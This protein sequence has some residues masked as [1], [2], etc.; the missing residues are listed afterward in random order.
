MDIPK[1]IIE[2]SCVLIHW[3]DLNFTYLGCNIEYTKYIGLRSQLDIIGKTDF[4]LFSSNSADQLRRNDKEA[5]KKGASCFFEEEITLPNG[6]TLS[7][8]TQKIP[9]FNDDGAVIGLASVLYDK[10]A[11]TSEN[12]IYIEKEKTEIVLTSLINKLPAHIYWKNDRLIFQGCN[13]AQAKSAGFSTPQQMIGK[14][15]YEMPWKKEATALRA[16][17]LEVM[18]TKKCIVQE[19]TSQLANTNELSTFLSEKVPLIDKKGNVIGVLGLSFNITERVKMEEEL[20]QTKIA[21]EAANRAKTEFIANM[22]HDL[23]TPIIGILGIANLLKDKM[24]ADEEKQYVQWVNESGEQLLNLLNDI[25]TK[26]SDGGEDQK[27][28]EELFDLRQCIN[29]IVQLEKPAIEL[30]QLSLNVMIAQD[31]PCYIISDRSKIYRILLNLLGNA[32]KFT[33]E[34][35]ITIEIKKNRSRLIFKIIDTGIGIAKE[36]QEKIFE[37]FFQ[38]AR[39]SKKTSPGYGIGLNLV[40][41]YVDLLNGKIQVSSQLGKGSTFTI[42]LPLKTENELLKTI[43]KYDRESSQ[44]RTY[45]LKKSTNELHVLLIEDNEIALRVL[46]NIVKNEKNCRFSSATSSEAALELIKKNVFDLIITDINLP[47]I[48]GNELAR[49]IREWE[50]KK[51]QNPIPIVGLT[52]DN[53]NKVKK[54]ALQS[55]MTKILEKPL[56]L[57]HLRSMIS[58]F[59][60]H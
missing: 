44:K 14:S 24:L 39:P 20:R 1:Q 15:D 50:A 7:Y 36:M 52:A 25:L 60:T 8:R 42:E 29:D 21:A 22:S 54:E 19:E 5:F 43:K 2:K 35:S 45:R 47:G 26:V 28:T 32:L 46:E 30:K 49:I 59:F 33:M 10:T 9:L 51:E 41:N 48:S 17:D 3:K 23:R 16:I 38:V 40:K 11:Q 56:K 31:V 37:R 34:G 58:E 57:D 6:S 12:S 4:D 13:K 18:R 53:S 55:G 27:V